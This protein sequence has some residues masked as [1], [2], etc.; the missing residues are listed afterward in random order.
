MV[1]SMNMSSLHDIYKKNHEFIGGCLALAALSLSV[2]L[3][4]KDSV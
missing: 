3:S 4:L 1:L 2:T